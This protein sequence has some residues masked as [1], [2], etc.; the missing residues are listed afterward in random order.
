MYAPQNSD[1][2]AAG[3]CVL[4]TAGAMVVVVEV[5]DVE[6]EVD[7]EVDVDDDVLGGVVVVV[8][9]VLVVLEVV[10]GAVVEVVVVVAAI[11]PPLLFSLVAEP[12][13]LLW[14]MPT[15]SVPENPISNDAAT[16]IPTIRPA[17]R[18]PSISQFPAMSVPSGRV[19]CHLN[20]LDQILPISRSYGHR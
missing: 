14:T 1:G 2:A 10:D 4:A 17:R 5:V 20:V 11:R 15:A 3:G 18:T 8:V 12:T 13:L 16:T 7:V 19:G 6:V 9:V